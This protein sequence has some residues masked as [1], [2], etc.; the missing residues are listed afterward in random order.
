M[1]SPESILPVYWEVYTYF[2]ACEILFK[3]TFAVQEFKIKS[4]YNGRI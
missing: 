3:L 1:T 2:S 4:C